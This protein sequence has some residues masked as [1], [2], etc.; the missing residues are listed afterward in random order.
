MSS[1]ITWS[2][3][4]R[5]AGAMGASPAPFARPVKPKHVAGG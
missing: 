1:A 2:A 5:S 3:R 4:S